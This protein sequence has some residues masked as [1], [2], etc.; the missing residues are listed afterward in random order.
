MLVRLR[1][2]VRICGTGQQRVLSRLLRHAPIEFPASPR[3]PLSRVQEF[4]RGPGA[5]TVSAHADVSDL[6]LAGPCCAGNR[7]DLVRFKRCIHG[8]SGALGLCVYFSQ[9]TAYGLSSLSIPIA[10]V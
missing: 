7:V 2:A 1:V 8:W 9:S 5:A 6:R 10:V 3:V 4:C